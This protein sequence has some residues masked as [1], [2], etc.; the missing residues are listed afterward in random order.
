MVYQS[1]CRW[2]S[3]T[4]VFF[5]AAFAA[6]ITGC[7]Q[8]PL[9]LTSSGIVA[10]TTA[11]SES[12]ALHVEVRTAPNQPPTSGVSTVELRVVDRTGAPFDGL[13]IAVTPWMPAMGHGTPT[14]AVVT[15]RGGG[16]Y[17]VAN[18]DLIMPGRWE[19]RCAISGPVTDRL[20]LALDVQ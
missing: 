7:A 2:A 14:E 19:L 12:G 9:A 5:F 6:T 20:T 10:L 8:T 18:V 13:S 16:V 4:F 3:A 1:V 11:T 17:S 15:A